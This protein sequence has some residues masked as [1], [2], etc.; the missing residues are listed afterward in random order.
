[1]IPPCLTLSNI[2]YISRVK[3]SN[4]GKGVVPSPTP[5]CYSYWKRSLLVTLDYGRQHYFTYF[6]ERQGSP[7]TFTCIVYIYIYIYR[8]REI[9]NKVFRRRFYYTHTHIYIYIY[10]Y[11]CKIN[12]FFELWR[13]DATLQHILSTMFLRFWIQSFSF[14][15][16]KC[17]TLTRELTVLYFLL[18][19]G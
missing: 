4:E 14:S 5:L 17:L 15:W 8:E 3:W 19:A 9:K 7:K 16:I 11:Y 6:K 12:H 2:L 10:I 18:I 1:M 13:N